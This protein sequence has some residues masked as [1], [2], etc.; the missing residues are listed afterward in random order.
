MKEVER[1]AKTTRNVVAFFLSHCG[2]E[3]E[4]LVDVS[5]GRGDS[6]LQ[7]PIKAVYA[8]RCSGTLKLVPR[9]RPRLKLRASRIQADCHTHYTIHKSL[10]YAS[11]KVI[12]KVDYLFI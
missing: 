5:Y 12:P 10:S 1:T 2:P 4:I 7:V 3:G 9:M 6:V 11:Y 8:L